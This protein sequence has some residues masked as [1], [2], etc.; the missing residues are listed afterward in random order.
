M[1]TQDRD[2]IGKDLSFDSGKQRDGG[3]R[4]CCDA[5]DPAEQTACHH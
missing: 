4:H 1:V 2:A 5:A 3:Q